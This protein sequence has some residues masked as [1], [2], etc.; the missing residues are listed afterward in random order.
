MTAGLAIRSWGVTAALVLAAAASVAATLLTG[1]NPVLVAAGVGF[2]VVLAAAAWRSGGRFEFDARGARPLSRR[3]PP[4]IRRAVLRVC[5][6]ADAPVPTVLVVEMDVPGAMVGRDDGHPVVAVDP[7]VL[8]VVGPEG[9]EALLA[10]ELGHL[11]V[12]LHADA[13]RQYLPQVIGFG[14]FWTV[15]LTW[16]SPAVATVGGLLY[17]GLAPVGDWRALVVRSACSL[18]AEPLALAASRYANRVEELR[19][20]AYAAAVVSPATLTEALY[21]LAA[22]ATGD[23][24]ED[25]AGPVP[26]EADRSP[27]FAAFATH[28]S[29]ERRARFLGCPI[30][31]WVRPHRPRTTAGGGREGVAGQE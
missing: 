24:D 25:V 2:V 7:R 30:P 1:G 4:A 28:P 9:L 23:N 11:S 20:D 14:V 10:H 5:E 6:R 17:V 29:I 31:E 19:A 27:L 12:D 16:Q 15:V 3:D 18:G 8:W 26:W 22:I 21:R 13:V